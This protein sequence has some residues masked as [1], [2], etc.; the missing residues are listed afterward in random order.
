M[1]SNTSMP[2]SSTVFSHVPKVGMSA[3]ELPAATSSM[4]G[5]IHFMTRPV[6]AASRP[7]SSAVL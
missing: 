7:Y 3:L 2:C 5:S 1:W 6:S 4:P